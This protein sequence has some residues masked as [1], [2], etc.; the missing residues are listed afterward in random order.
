MSW[1][2]EASSKNNEGETVWFH[3]FVV[4]DMV[5]VAVSAVMRCG[6]TSAESALEKE[7]ISALAS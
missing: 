1:T 7:I 2:I 6:S 5:L 3:K 4:D